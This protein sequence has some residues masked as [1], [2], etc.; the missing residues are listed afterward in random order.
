[1]RG[2]GALARL[3]A[4]DAE[5]GVLQTGKFF[6]DERRDLLQPEVAQALQARPWLYEPYFD[7]PGGDLLARLQHADQKTYLPDDVLVKVDR[8]AM[9]NSLE[10]RVPFLDH[11]LVEFLNRAPS[12][13]KLQGDR[14]KVPLRRLLERTLP[15]DVHARGKKGFGIPIRDWFRG[16]LTDEVRKVLLAP[17]S[18]SRRFL[19]PEAISRLLDDEARGGRDLSRKIWALLVFEYWCRE[20]GIG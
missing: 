10:V 17:D 11:T 15:K 12:S 5:R 14:T 19:R 1:V 2:Q 13:A 6:P 8:M 20:Y 3:G 7:G 16:G 18:R 9:Q 4:Q